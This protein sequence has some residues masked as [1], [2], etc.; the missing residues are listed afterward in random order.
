MDITIA[1]SVVRTALGSVDSG[2]VDEIALVLCR[3][4]AVSSELAD[5]AARGLLSAAETA[6]A[7]A[8]AHAATE[9]EIRRVLNDAGAG[10]SGRG[11][12]PSPRKQPAVETYDHDAGPSTRTAAEMLGVH[13]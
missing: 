7:S 1:E 12:P 6:E 3:H 10:E 9:R 2:L 11:V 4:S 8:R 5:S 13:I